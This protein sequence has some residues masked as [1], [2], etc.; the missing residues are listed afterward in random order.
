M[1]NDNKNQTNIRIADLDFLRS[2]LVTG[3]IQMQDMKPNTENKTEVLIWNLKKIN[4][5]TVRKCRNKNGKVLKLLYQHEGN[6]K[7]VEYS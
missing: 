2:V 1:A 4:S 3:R 6:Y 5:T 7:V